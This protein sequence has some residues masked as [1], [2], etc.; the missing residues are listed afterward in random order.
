MLVPARE[1]GRGLHRPRHRDRPTVLLASH[2]Y[3]AVTDVPCADQVLQACRG[4]PA[5]VAHH[6]VLSA[7]A[8][9]ADL[10]ARQT[11]HPRAD[12]DE[13]AWQRATLMLV[14]D[15]CVAVSTPTP[16]PAARVHTETVGGVVDRLAQFTVDA[17]R[18]LTGT[19]DDEYHRAC[20]RLADLATAYQ[21]LVDELAAGT[22]RLPRL[23]RPTV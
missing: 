4:C 16:F 8:E 13:I 11:R 12:A 20:N 5:A 23:D 18:A 2:P 7:A 15:K 9:L 1:V 22:R 3:R 10:H 19:A 17:Y 6:P 21:D 14:I